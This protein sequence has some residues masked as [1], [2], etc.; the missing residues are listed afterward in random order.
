MHAQAVMGIGCGVS[1]VLNAIFCC[2]IRCHVP[3]STFCL[4]ALQHAAGVDT[5]APG[6]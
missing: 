6:A 4:Q 3:T 2:W 5:F 1:S